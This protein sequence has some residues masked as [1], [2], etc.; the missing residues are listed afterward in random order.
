MKSRPLER[1]PALALWLLVVVADLALVV[2]AVGAVATLSVLAGL[3]AVGTVARQARTQTRV[4]KV[5]TSGHARQRL[6]QRGA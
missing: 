6:S 2:S 1:K 3:L 4:A 5:S